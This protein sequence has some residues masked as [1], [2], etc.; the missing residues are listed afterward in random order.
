M[1]KRTALGVIALIAIPMFS[2][3]AS[4]E[5]ENIAV[6]R[7]ALEVNEVGISSISTTTP[8]P[9]RTAPNDAAR[10]FQKTED[11]PSRSK[12]GDEIHS[13]AGPPRP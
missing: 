9:V 7:T 3:R 12:I 5:Q 13:F 10:S 2:A 1:N 6:G 4:A 11:L 8:I